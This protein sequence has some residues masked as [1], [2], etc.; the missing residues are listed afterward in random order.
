[1]QGN[2]LKPR[3]SEHFHWVETFDEYTSGLIDLINAIDKIEAVH[4]IIKLHPAIEISENDLKLLLPK[5]NKYTIY[6]DMPFYQVLSAGDICISFGSTAIEDALQNRIP[7]L[8]YDKWGRYK[9][10][11]ALDINNISISKKSWI[12][13]INRQED[14]QK[15]LTYMLKD[16]K[17]KEIPNSELMKY[18]YLDNNKNKN[19][20]KLLQEL[21]KD[22][23]ENKL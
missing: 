19:F 4:L 5:S 12:Y 6:K 13:Y 11:E 10:C 16:L 14:L 1:V 8:L 23:S 22:K 7:V 15:S 9:H 2:T 3:G 17:I 20:Y 18:R 21:L